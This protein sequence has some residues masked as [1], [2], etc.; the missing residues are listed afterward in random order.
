VVLIALK[1][2]SL[3]VADDSQRR[4]A[5]GRPGVSLPDGGTNVPVTKE[6]RVG[7]RDG[8]HRGPLDLVRFSVAP[9][10]P[11]SDLVSLPDKQKRLGSCSAAS[12]SHHTS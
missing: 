7:S 11:S 3:T 4:T 9:A 12:F 2:R 6:E 8:G 10:T 5:L 1:R